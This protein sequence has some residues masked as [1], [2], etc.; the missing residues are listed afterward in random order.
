M[1]TGRDAPSFSVPRDGT[2]EQDGTRKMLIHRITG[3][4][5]LYLILFIKDVIICFFRRFV[6]HNRKI[7]KKI[8]NKVKKIANQ[9]QELCNLIKQ[10]SIFK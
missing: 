3:W 4:D 7:I 1:Q 6:L 5:K 9:N 8:M 10:L 2:M